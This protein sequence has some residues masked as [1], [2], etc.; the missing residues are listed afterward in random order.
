MSVEKKRINITLS[1]PYLDALNLLVE[2]GIYLERQVVIRAA[3]RRLFNSH[4]I[5]PFDL[6]EVEP[7]KIIEGVEGCPNCGAKPGE[8]CGCAGY[9]ATGGD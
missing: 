7:G 1:R 5:P 6:L 2:K 3:L 8:V 9:E 4:R